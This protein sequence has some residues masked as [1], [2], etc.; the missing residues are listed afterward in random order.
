MNIDRKFQT[1]RKSKVGT[2]KIR[3][4]FIKK[5]IWSRC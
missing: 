2:E 5:H 3:V 1:I 4:L